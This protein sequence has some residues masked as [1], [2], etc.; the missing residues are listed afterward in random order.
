MRRLREFIKEFLDNLLSR[1]AVDNY[2]PT[3]EFENNLSF[4]LFFFCRTDFYGKKLQRVGKS[5]V[6]QNFP[7]LVNP[8]FELL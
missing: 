4:F 6:E 1:A 3:W 5:S 8:I 2:L 7:F